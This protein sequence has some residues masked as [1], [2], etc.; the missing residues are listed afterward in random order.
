MQPHILDDIHATVDHF[1]TR[2]STT[3]HFKRESTH[4]EN[5]PNPMGPEVENFHDER[6]RGQQVQPQNMGTA[7]TF[8][9]RNFN[10]VEGVPN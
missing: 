6:W 5:G 10:R 1:Y 7:A 9:T 2:K 8:Y 3:Q 4:F